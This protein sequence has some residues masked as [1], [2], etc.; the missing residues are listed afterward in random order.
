M[1]WH[2]DRRG[3]CWKGCHWSVRQDSAEDCQELSS[4]GFWQTCEK[5]Y[6]LN[7]LWSYCVAN[8]YSL[9]LY[10]VW[11]FSRSCCAVNLHF[12]MLYLV[13]L[14]FLL[15]CNKLG[16]YS[17]LHICLEKLSS[18]NCFIASYTTN[19]LTPRTTVRMSKS[20]I[21]DCQRS[22]IIRDM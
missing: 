14:S 20:K 9:I 8:L 11:I 5:C 21:F 18:F 6:L 12:Y 4:P 10:H 3:V 7:F 17:H 22:G 1:V 19:R 16:T 13:W 2:H 15:K